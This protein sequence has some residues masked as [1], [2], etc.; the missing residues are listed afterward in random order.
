MYTDDKI[1]TGALFTLNGLIAVYRCPSLAKKIF[2]PAI[3][4]DFAFEP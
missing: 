4:P 3:N 2:K 1:T